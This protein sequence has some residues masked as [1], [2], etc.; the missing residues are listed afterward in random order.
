MFE[1]IKDDYRRCLFIDEDSQKPLKSFLR[2]LFL[3]PGFQILL[4]YRFGR[5][6]LELKKWKFTYLLSL[7]LFPIYIL[8]YMFG[9][10]LFDINISI[11]ADI[12]KGFYIG[13]YMGIEVGPCKIGEYCSIHQHVKINS[14]ITSP[15]LI[16]DRVWI[17]SHSTV[18]KGV[19]LADGVTISGGTYI[20]F[21]VH[22][23]SLLIGRPAKI[24][25]KSFNNND[26]LC[27]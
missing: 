17:G 9:R 6:L 15:T 13:H 26:L 5:W 22:G 10:Y 1:Y 27:I 11:E 16:G 25:M 20:D 7:V 23:D 8:L 14:D 12:G 21:S 24:I 4:I 2:V 18:E 3:Y 19:V